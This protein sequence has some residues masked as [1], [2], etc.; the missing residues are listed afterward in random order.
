MIQDDAY[1]SMLVSCNMQVLLLSLLNY[2]LYFVLLLVGR[3][4]G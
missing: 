3:R 4:N 2:K 1:C